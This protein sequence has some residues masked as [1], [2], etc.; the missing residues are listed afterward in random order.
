MESDYRDHSIKD[1]ITSNPAKYTVKKDQETTYI[2]IE[3]PRGCFEIYGSLTY[4]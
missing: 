1:L 2:H 3:G 4:D